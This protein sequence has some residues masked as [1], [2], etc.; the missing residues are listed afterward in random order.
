MEN[1]GEVLETVEQNREA[2]E[3]PFDRRVAVTMA[4]QAAILATVT[5]LGHQSNDDALEQ[6]IGAGIRQTESSNQWGYYQAKNIRNQ[7]NKGN[8]QLL[9]LLEKIP[10]NETASKDAVKKLT[11]EI[12]KND[13]D[14]EEIR[15]K[16]ETLAKESAELQEKSKHAK[17]LGDHFDLAEFC[18]QLGLVLSSLAVLTKRRWFWYSGIIVA[19]LGVG[20][21]AWASKGFF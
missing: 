17:E 6:Q 14:K 11:A 7:V 4:M 1:A 9:P 15:K 13:A 2:T 21:G 16:A 8:L 5:M 18:M 3:L 19:V 12:A 20:V 10:G